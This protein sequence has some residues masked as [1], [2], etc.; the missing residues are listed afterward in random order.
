[1]RILRA[2]WLASPLVIVALPLVSQPS[3]TDTRL[4]SQPALSA[5]RVAF[6]YAGDLWSSRLDGTDVMRLT[7]ADGDEQN[8]VFSPDGKFVAFSGNYDGNTDVYVVPATGG[9]P[10]R[11]TWHPGDDLVQA[12]APDGRAVLFTSPRASYTTRYTQLF[13][14]PVDGGIATQLPIP[15]AARATFSPDGK[16]IAYNPIAPAFEQ[17]KHYRGGR[18][19]TVWIY[20]VATHA[21]TTIP[22]PPSRSNDVDA[23]WI[24]SRLIFRSDRDGEFNLYSYDTASRQVQQL[25]RYTDFP[26]LNVGVDGGSGRL[27]F[28]QAGYLHLLEPSARTPARKLTFGVATDLREL[29]PRYAK[30]PHYVRN[31]AIGPTGAR[32]AFEYRGEIVTLPAEKGDARN[33]TNSTAANDR[34]P[35]WSPDGRQVAFVTDE[36]GEYLLKIVPQDGQ[37]IAKTFKL[38]GKGFYMTL[39]WSPNGEWI[40]YQDNSQSVYVLNVKTGS[41]RRVGG[42]GI[43][44]PTPENPMS[45]AWSPDSRWLAY[46]VRVRS[47]VNVL[48]LYDVAA[49]KSTQITDGLS[50]VTS[51][52]FDRSG[53]YLYVFASTDAGP[54]Q[55]WFS[56]A[57]VDFTR[58][59][60][61]Y[62]IVLRNDLPNPLAR[63][64]DEEKAPT[65][66]DSA[67]APAAVGVD[68]DGIEHRI[69]ALPIPA[70]VLERLQAGD[71][72]Q[73]YYI[74]TLD[75]KNQLHHFDMGK[76]RDETLLPDVTTFMLSDDGR[77]VLYLTNQNWY[78]TSLAKITPGEGR[79]AIGEVDVRI[80]PRAEWGQIFAEA[81]RINRDYFYAP[82]MHG[83]N[84][85]ANRHKYEPFLADATTRADVN[86]IIQWMMSDL[87]VGHH[88]GGGGDRLN[89]PRTVPVGLLGADYTV[90]NG[91]YRFARV[92]GGLNWT[93]GL[94]SP[95]TEPGVNARAGEYLLA[96][97]GVELQPPANLYAA[98]E[99]TAGRIV[100]I[101][102][103]PNANG[104]GARTVQVV[105]HDNES[106]LRNRAW[107]EGNLHKVDSAT[108]GRVAYVYVPNTAEP[109]HTYFK[110]YFYPQTNK[111]AII[112]DERFNGGGSFADYYI[113]ILRRPF[114]S[115]WAMRY[116]EDLKTPTAS[117]Q[118]PKAMIIDETA[119]SGGD[120]L[121]WMFRNLGLGP[122]IGK[123]TWG[124][125]V[126]VLG[127]PVLMDGG[128]ITAPNFAI[129]TPDQGWVV[130]NEGVAPDIEVEQTPADVIAGRDPQLQ[131][132]IDVV[133]E[134]LR[135][136][137]PKTPK[138]P[139]Y[140]VKVPR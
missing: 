13:T 51:P 109:G 12:F 98:F 28:E 35:A 27:V 76:R 99:N 79:L 124:G 122:L 59:R 83:V 91:R 96:V 103:G 62:A 6:I 37:G 80:D 69:L 131:R 70:A 87:A 2:A 5:E 53:K 29:R 102:I 71:V 139:P 50:E 4:L 46:A 93:P 26:V 3:T 40:A 52:A 110:R 72:G 140:P 45:Y 123:R 125:L 56:Q 107:V 116:G 33:L 77:K 74:R 38:T 106:A 133:M 120:L 48:Y 58:T 10:K 16:H 23:Q 57:T 112:V 30:G 36:S 24:G 94:R 128:S 126:G 67:R 105:P 113:D 127:F 84:W 65:P 95:L 54:V 119:G 88:R 118:G 108:A 9:V 18:T 15:N 75:G 130:E 73:L 115:Y 100:A 7:S 134:A 136:D 19:S 47:M 55:D 129:W 44:G 81:W 1:M 32:V 138:R 21:V 61:I 92:Y 137:P 20:D 8:P 86:R 43:Y 31:A 14:V 42:N 121:P 41:S 85:E 104:S 66:R 49:D 117:I 60:S 39:A 34:S 11:L 89:P 132:A 63:E 82:N 114:I 97:D 22:Q 64:S 25:T 78:V 17:W 68:F 101:T 90:E 135:R 111:D